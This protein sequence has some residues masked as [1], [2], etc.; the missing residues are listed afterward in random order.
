[1]ARTESKNRDIALVRIRPQHA[2]TPSGAVRDLN[3]SFTAKGSTVNIK[4]TDGWIRIDADDLEVREA[5]LA[6]ARELPPSDLPPYK[7][8]RAFDVVRGET[9]EACQ[10]EIAKLDGLYSEVQREAS[11][12]EAA[13]RRMRLE[14]APPEEPQDLGQAHNPRPFKVAPARVS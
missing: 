11:A 4:A 14:D 1:M 6:R 5:L 13:L 12:L 8:Q 3:W 9:L 10:A 7:H 2:I